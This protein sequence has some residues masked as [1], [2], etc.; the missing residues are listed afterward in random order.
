MTVP[1]SGLLI[2]VSSQA[3]GYSSRTAVQSHHEQAVYGMK[4]PAIATVGSDTARSFKKATVRIQS[5]RVCESVTTMVRNIR[6]LIRDALDVAVD[7]HTRVRCSS[8]QTYRPQLVL[9]R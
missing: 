8:G 2:M 1:Q 5:M 4:Y 9:F 3:G 6:T 7:A